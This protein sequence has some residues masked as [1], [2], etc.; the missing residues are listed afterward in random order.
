MGDVT[1]L[2]AFG[3]GIAS[4]ASPCVVPLVP[5]YF[6]SIAG[7][8][9]LSNE[10]PSRRHILINT[11]LFILGFSLIFIL[12]GTVLTVAFGSVPISI[13][14]KVAGGLLILFGTYLF[15]AT[16]IPRLNFERRLGMEKVSASGYIRSFLIGAVF[17]VGWTPCI[18]PFIGSIMAMASY[19]GNVA[20]ALLPLTAYCL[21]LGLPFVVMGALMGTPKASK[22]MRWMNQRAYL[23]TTIGSIILVVVGLLMFFGQI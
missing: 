2:V 7:L 22:A 9:V 11:A 3:L 8:S 17:A 16:K 15:A 20:E 18:G 10:P 1:L 14:Q 23:A 6:A 12:M 13:K 21:G 4:F 19:G 5:V